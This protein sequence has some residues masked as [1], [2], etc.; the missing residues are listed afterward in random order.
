MSVAEEIIPP[1]VQEF[2]KEFAALANKHN[3]MRASA[4]IQFSSFKNPNNWTQP[5]SISWEAGQRDANEFR[6]STTLNIFGKIKL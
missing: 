1:N 5:V 3:L 4:S 2:A 6:I